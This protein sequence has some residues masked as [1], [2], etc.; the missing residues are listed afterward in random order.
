MVH[1][2]DFWVI[3]VVSGLAWWVSGWLAQRQVVIRQRLTWWFERSG[4]CLVASGPVWVAVR[5]QVVESWQGVRRAWFS[6]VHPD[7]TLACLVGFSQP[8]SVWVCLRLA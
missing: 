1:L 7:S 8:G 5:Q 4:C 3:W 2:G 6:L